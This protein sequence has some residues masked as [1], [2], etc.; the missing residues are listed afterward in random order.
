MKRP[1]MKL[2]LT[3]QM[4]LV[5]SQLQSFTETKAIL[6]FKLHLT[7]CFRQAKVVKVNVKVPDGQKVLFIKDKLCLQCVVVNEAV[8]ADCLKRK[9]PFEQNA[10]GSTGR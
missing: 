10:L 7:L 8:F 2:R 1:Q 4:S 3:S 5:K 6:F 9:R